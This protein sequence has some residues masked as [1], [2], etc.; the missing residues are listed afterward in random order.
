MQK[1]VAAWE[2][3][4]RVVAGAA[5]AVAGAV[6]LWQAGAWGYRALAGAGVLL[7]LDLVITGAIGVCPLYH[8]LGRHAPSGR[9]GALG[10]DAR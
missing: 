3:L 9:R 8:A 4:V 7:G 5:L 10:P 6:V 1:N 2:R